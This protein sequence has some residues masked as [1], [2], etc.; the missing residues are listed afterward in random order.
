MNTSR[1]L[2]SPAYLLEWALT[3]KTD[4]SGIEQ[5]YEKPEAADN[6]L[7]VRRDDADG[8]T[9]LD[10]AEAFEL[11]L[12]WCYVRLVLNLYVASSRATGSALDRRCE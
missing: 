2:E 9:E 5:G 12:I 1:Q 3:L 10:T 7:K 6:R 4:E 8:Q 11:R